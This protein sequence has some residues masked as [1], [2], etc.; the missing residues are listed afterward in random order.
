MDVSLGGADDEKLVCSKCLLTIFLIK[1]FK[2]F[3]KVIFPV[4]VESLKT[5][6]V[7]TVKIIYLLIFYL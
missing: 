2:Y 5:C 4:I 6:K 1:L 7:K 3:Y